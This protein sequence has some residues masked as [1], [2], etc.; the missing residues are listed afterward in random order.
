MILVAS[1][2]ATA[3]FGTTILSFLSVLLLVLICL[4]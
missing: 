1:I 4:I 3:G 2:I